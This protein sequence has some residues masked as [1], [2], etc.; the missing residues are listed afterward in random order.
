LF[1]FIFLTEFYTEHENVKKQ[2]VKF[3]TGLIVKELTVTAVVGEMK[4][5][6]TAYFQGQTS[7]TMCHD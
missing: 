3:G 2:F 6:C 7:N 5:A 1:S 4:E